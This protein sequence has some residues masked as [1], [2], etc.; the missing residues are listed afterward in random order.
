MPSLP[1]DLRYAL[2][3]MARSPGWA[4]A[5]VLSFALGAGANMAIFSLTYAVVL[6][7]LP[8]PEPARLIRYTF[9]NGEQEIGLSGPL[10]QA[11]RRQQSVATGLLAWSDHD[12]TFLHNGR[13]GRLRGALLSGNGFRVLG[14]RPF[15]GRLF[16]EQDD[17][18]DGGANGFQAV[19]GYDYWQT[20][21]NADRSLLGRSLTLDG[22]RVTVI[23]ILPP[24][25]PNLIAGMG[26]G[27][28]AILPLSFEAAHMHAPGSF[29]LTVMGRLKPGQSL[30]SA[31]A[32]LAAL[33]S[34]VRTE[35]DPS[36]RMLNGFF[37]AFKIGVEDGS[38]GRSFLRNAYARPLLV[39]ELLSGALL[40][41][42]CANTALLIFAR[43]SSRIRE[44]AVRSALGA[45]QARLLRQV[46]AEILLLAFAGLLAAIALGW[47]LARSL[48]QM[49][50][51]P[52][53][54]GPGIT[55]TP[56]PLVLAAVAAL[57]LLAALAA[58]LWPALR[59]SR[60]DPGPHL[61][62]RAQGG[63][64]G[65]AGGW[66][67]QFQVAASVTLVAGSLLLGDS[68]LH[69]L[70]LDSGFRPDHVTLADVDLRALKLTPAETIQAVRRATDYLES[71]PTIT[72]ATVLTMAPFTGWSASEYY[73]V[74]N[75][76]EVRQDANAW[77]QPVSPGYFAAMGTRI[78]EG[79]ALRKSDLQGPQACVVSE[80][81]AQ[82]FFPGQ[83]PV[84]RTLYTANPSASKAIDP[85]N[86]C[87][88]VGLAE[89][90]RYKSLREPPPR[91]IYSLMTEYSSPQ[92][93]LAV[94]SNAAAQA[95][96]GLRE[97]VRQAAPSAPA[98]SIYTFSQLVDWHLS[99][100]RMLI[101][102]AGS[103]AAI[104]L[105]LTAVGLFGLMMRAVAQ[106]SHEIGVRMA[107]GAG[108]AQ[109]ARAV[110]ARTAWQ[111]L[112]GLAAG[113]LLGSYATEWMKSLLTGVSP[114]DLWIYAGAGALILAVGF[115]AAAL[116]LRRAL[117][118]D[119]MEALRS[120]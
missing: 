44:F 95:V 60:V 28:E 34:S 114:G 83:D 69:L 45:G 4:A 17:Q 2:R 76:G 98:P 81:A 72:A 7:T 57:T 41:L 54:E 14:V 84:G 40:L 5:V 52:A 9:R 21:W 20:H 27:V 66:I 51:T 36:G 112:T 38:G 71:A 29:W 15:L 67:V 80:A 86:T 46:L 50:V 118:I 93:S 79:R 88:I 108:P 77:G 3:M 101:R 25:F 55:V 53:G 32:N 43:I 33:Q 87:R 11:L 92:F 78:L 64:S 116:P 82:Y 115:L 100:E 94:R 19:L 117:A 104:A 73:A 102:L 31:R 119:P 62:Q 109:V 6:K 24:G 35:G 12:F 30:E 63:L 103:F 111:V 113:T 90:A 97:A 23:G 70:L 13:A 68:F 89:D 8:V 107:L 61:K 10:Y 42:C 96:A 47:S 1:S 39:L 58:G 99:R 120:E 49:L 65:A 91:L 22:Q 105:L 18:P 26:G 59:A 75:G 106:R 85:Q 56:N 37:S 16:G 74:G 110:F 48:V